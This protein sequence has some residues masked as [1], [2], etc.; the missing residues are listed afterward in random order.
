[1]RIGAL[2]TP[3][4]PKK[5]WIL[6]KIVYKDGNTIIWFLRLTPPFLGAVFIYLNKIALVY[7]SM[8]IFPSLWYKFQVCRTY[9]CKD[10]QFFMI[11]HKLVFGSQPLF[12]C[13]CS[14]Y[15][16]LWYFRLNETDADAFEKVDNELSPSVPATSTLLASSLGP[17]VST[18]STDSSSTSSATLLKNCL[19]I[20][21]S[22]AFELSPYY[23]I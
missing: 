4:L 1:M 19:S 9:H 8:Y 7:E 6:D 17:S 16:N 11:F 15:R 10:K 21:C 12:E 23:G 22:S 5:F 3:F 14:S 18:P 13:T 20:C 2:G